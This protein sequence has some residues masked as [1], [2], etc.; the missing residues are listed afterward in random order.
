MINPGDKLS[1]SDP[2]LVIRQ[3]SCQLAAFVNHLCLRCSCLSKKQNAS[4]AS[5]GQTYHQEECVFKALP[6]E[7]LDSTLLKQLFREH[8]CVIV[9]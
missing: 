1:T 7:T 6:L 5:L 9:L 4:C 8:Y 2:S 3:S